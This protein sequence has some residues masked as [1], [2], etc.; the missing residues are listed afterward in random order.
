MKIAV[1]IPKYGLVGGAE[2]FAYELTERLAQRD[3]F[4]IHVFANKWRRGKSAVTFHKVPHLP[5]PRFMRP[6]NF[7]YFSNRRI[8]PEDY[9]LIHS[10]D[11]IF[12][13][14]IFTVHGIPHKT[15]I[16]EARVKPLSLFDRSMAWVEE[17][18]LTGPYL[19]MIL[20]VSTLVKDEL[21]KTY[22]IPES[23]I[24][25][26]HPGV[27]IDRFKVLDQ[28]SCRYEIRQRHGLSQSDIVV[29]FV[30]MNFEIKRL[31][32]VL[33]GIAHLVG[34]EMTNSTL[35]LLVVGKGDER[36]Y[37]DMARD[38]G[39]QN[40]IFFAGVSSEVEKYYLASDIFTMPSQFD[41]FGLAVLEAMTAGLPVII[42]QKVGARDLIDPGVDG[43]V[44]AKDPSPLDLSE[45]LAF[46]MMKE[47][48]MRL[49]DNA[50]KAALQHSWDE[51]AD[52][53]ADLYHKLVPRGNPV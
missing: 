7:A 44:L 5:F 16:R 3:E 43:F 12:T 23:N 14:S 17:K 50:R 18:A 35:K 24:Q 45:K 34:T 10:H 8:H 48:R 4:K 41:T 47:N 36:R 30:G 2:A 33:K 51:V 22:D 31:Q 28:E 25:V 29:L 38:L 40:R 37:L 53:V 6:I 21:L 27:S 13:M 39:I 1:V 49:G 9:D 19:P 15:W 46:L 42:T 20:P 26:I 52:Q 11:R 32:L